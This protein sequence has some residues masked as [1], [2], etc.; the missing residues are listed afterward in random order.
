MIYAD[1]VRPGN[2]NDALHALASGSFRV[3]AGGTD[4]YPS[5]SATAPKVSL[6]DITGVSDLTGISLQDQ[7]WRIGATT[8]WST[9]ARAELPPQLS[10][11]QAAAREVGGIQ[12]QN[13]GTV[14]GNICNA[15]PAADGVPVLLSLDAEVELA[16]VRGTRRIPL[17]QFLMGS[18]KTARNPDELV[19]AL[20]IPHRPNARSAF[21]KL[22][23]RRYLVIS[24]VMAAAVVEIERGVLTHV[25]LSV[26]ACS[27]VAQRLNALERKLIGQPANSALV[28]QINPDDLLMLSPIDDV[29]GTANYRVDAALALVRRVITEAT[30]E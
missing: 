24:I 17:Q 29:R 8:T 20:V 9:L 10:G 15:S 2:L 18:R 28:D 19:T 30:H 22:G 13:T 7:V 25:A 4:I 27:A 16:S 11:L 12:I 21:L 14:A 3:L 1:Y 6:L 23:H 5:D 26:G